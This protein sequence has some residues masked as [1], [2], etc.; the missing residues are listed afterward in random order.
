MR[1]KSRV[2]AMERACGVGRDIVVPVVW[3]GRDE[4]RVR[5]R[6]ERARERGWKLRIIRVSLVDF[7]DS[8]EE[9]ERLVEQHRSGG[10]ALPVAIRRSATGPDGE[11]LAEWDPGLPEWLS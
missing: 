1:M 8:T 9:A 7:A 10:K 2:A 6:V 3:S 11:V 4:E 5:S